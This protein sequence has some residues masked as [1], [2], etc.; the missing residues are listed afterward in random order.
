MENCRLKL[1][2]N[3]EKKNKRNRIPIYLRVTLGRKKSERRL[4]LEISE[5]EFQL[6]DVVDERLKIKT[7]KINRDLESLKHRFEELR[8]FGKFDKLTEK[9]I[10]AILFEENANEDITWLKYLDNYYISSICENSTITPATKTNYRKAINHMRRFISHKG[11]VS[12]KLTSIDIRFAL[13]FKDYCLNN[14]PEIKKV[15]MCEASALGIIKKFRTICS[16]AIDEAIIERNPFSAVILKGA[17]KTKE[18]LT[19]SEVKDICQLDLS[20]APKLNVYR[21]IFLCIVYTGISYKD[22]MGLTTRSLIKLGSELQMIKLLRDKTSILVENILVKNVVEIVDRYSHLPAR[23]IEGYL[24]PRRSNTKINDMLKVIAERAKITRL[25]LTSNIG[26]H[27]FR[28][29]LGEAGIVEPG[30]IKRMMGHSTNSDIDSTYYCI[31][32]S[33]LIDAKNKLEL[34]LDK[35]L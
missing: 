7:N 3:L 10:V 6:W 35:H 1:F 18:R 8:Y 25:S 20:G 14:I 4:H 13:Q 5:D 17:N 9:Q 26:R 34:F 24:L 2:P 28:Q 33:K 30:V 23:Q 21:D 11:L 15:G 19:I 16:R 32:E 29:L 12:I 22:L 31:T 27:T